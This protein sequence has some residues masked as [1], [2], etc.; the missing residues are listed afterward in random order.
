MKVGFTVLAAYLTIC[1][2]YIQEE[3]RIN[4]GRC[5]STNVYHIKHYQQD[6]KTLH[7][8][9]KTLN[10]GNNKYILYVFYT[11]YYNLFTS[12]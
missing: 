1:A 4:N 2:A 11:F 3:T 12:T 5:R 6:V 10:S 8:V 7:E 9:K